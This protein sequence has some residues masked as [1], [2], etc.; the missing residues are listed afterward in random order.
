MDGIMT[1]KTFFERGDI[2]LYVTIG[3]KTKAALVL[4]MKDSPFGDP[5][6]MVSAIT[7]ENT[8]PMHWDLFAATCIYVGSIA[9]IYPDF[10]YA[11]F[12]L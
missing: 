1:T 3:G 10:D 2:V 9:E 5:K 11:A 8:K 12:G 4:G 7:Y 6:A